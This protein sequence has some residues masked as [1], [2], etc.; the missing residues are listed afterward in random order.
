[1]NSL[2]E[3][4][5]QKVFAEISGLNDDDFYEMEGIVTGVTINDF[6]FHEKNEPIY[7]EVTVNPIDELPKDYQEMLLDELVFVPLGKIR[8]AY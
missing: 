7:I 3:L 6:Y 4:V 8:K 1:M 2:S 5:G